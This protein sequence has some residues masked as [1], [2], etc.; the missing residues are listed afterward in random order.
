[1]C[2]KFAD[3]ELA[4]NAGKWDKQ[5]EFPREAITHL[6]ELGL[7][8]ISTPEDCGGSG[9]DAMSYAIAMVSTQSHK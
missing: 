4:P 1:M 7:M 9:L 5:H 8:G 6:A 3:E 2:R